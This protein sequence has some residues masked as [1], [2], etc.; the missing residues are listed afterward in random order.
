MLSLFNNSFWVKQAEMWWVA[1]WVLEQIISKICELAILVGITG[2]A[3]PNSAWYWFGLFMH[4]WT[5]GSCL[6]FPHLEIDWLLTY[7]MELT[8][9]IFRPLAQ[10]CSYHGGSRVP[11]SSTCIKR[12]HGLPCK[13]FANLCLFLVF[14]Y[15]QCII[16]GLQRNRTNVYI[17]DLYI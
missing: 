9:L 16:Q 11:K 8:P 12:S 10:V 13:Y 3:H 4:S 2:M 6:L 14:L 17:F 7:M 5:A 1:L 15:W